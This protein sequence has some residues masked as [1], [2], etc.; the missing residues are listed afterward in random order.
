MNG[1]L[2][3]RGKLFECAI[4]EHKDKALELVKA[5][6]RQTWVHVTPDGPF[7]E[8]PLTARQIKWIQ[9]HFSQEDE[10]WRDMASL[11]LER[12][13]VENARIN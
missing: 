5:G 8:R 10:T 9:A 4:G 6:T 2:S 13:G 12:N 1:W 7:S 3:P 11:L